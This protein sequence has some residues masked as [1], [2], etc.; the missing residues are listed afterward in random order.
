MRGYRVAG[1]FTRYAL[2]LSLSGCV[3][4]TGALLQNS[5]QLLLLGAVLPHKLRVRTRDRLHCHCTGMHV[6]ES[7]TE[8]VEDLL[9]SSCKCD[10]AVG[11]QTCETR[12]SASCRGNAVGYVSSSVGAGT[13]RHGS[14]DVFCGA[15]CAGARR[16]RRRCQR[17][18]V[19][20][21]R[22]PFS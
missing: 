20:R 19:L 2:H 4:G 10:L 8:S 6:G 11:M 22:L 15:H 13:A 21:V 18:L 5:P 3:T 1:P 7:A 12:L 9:G 14:R 16:H 17:R